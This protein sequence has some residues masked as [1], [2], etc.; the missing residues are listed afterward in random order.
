MRKN[1]TTCQIS[2]L[3]SQNKVNNIMDSR[4]SCGTVCGDKKG[5]F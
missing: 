1:V 3:N 5:D 2:F 4:K